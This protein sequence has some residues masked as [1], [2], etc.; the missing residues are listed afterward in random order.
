MNITNTD[1]TYIFPCYSNFR[2][3][4]NYLKN[5]FIFIFILIFP[6]NI[7]FIFFISIFF[8]TKDT[9]QMCVLCWFFS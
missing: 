9:N 4:K 2:K 8:L 5:K 3:N 1:R 6:I 7:F